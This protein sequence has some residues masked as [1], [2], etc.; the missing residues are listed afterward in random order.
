MK[1]AVL[2]FGDGVR[3]FV[4][5]REHNIAE[6]LKKLG[7]EVI[8]QDLQ[9]DF[10]PSARIG[11]ERKKAKDFAAS[12]IDKRLFQQAQLLS[13]NFERSIF[14]I[15]GCIDEIDIEIKKEA[16]LGAIVALIL[17]FGAQILFSKNEA[18]S[19]KLI[20]AIAKREQEKKERT[21]ATLPKRR[22]FSIEYKQLRVLEAFPNIGPKSARA[23]L[24]HFKSLR[25]I[26][27]ADVAA[28]A[29]VIGKARANSFVQLTGA[30][31]G[32]A[33]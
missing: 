21:I 27:D 25:K 8:L 2:E 24:K 30:R 28:L 5:R 32:A 6:Q 26:F 9:V 10:I 23:L 20:Y 18:E 4:D 15:E 7:A 31:C 13:E 17:D 33:F 16:L 19:A 12:I 11:I 1:Q 22:A 14:I 3:I 29:Q